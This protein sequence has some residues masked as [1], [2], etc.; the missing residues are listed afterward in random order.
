[1]FQLDKKLY[2]TLY[3]SLSVWQTQLEYSNVVSTLIFF[4][5]FLLTHI[6]W[7]CLSRLSRDLFALIWKCAAIANKNKKFRLFV[8]KIKKVQKKPQIFTKTNKWHHCFISSFLFFI[9]WTLINFALFC[10]FF[11]LSVSCLLCF[12]LIFSSLSSRSARLLLYSNF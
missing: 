4:Y 5:S 11:V 2:L 1:M 7:L 3:D 10:T 12:L 6:S 8:H 9:A